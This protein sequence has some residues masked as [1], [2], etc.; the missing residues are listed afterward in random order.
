[1]DHRLEE[2]MNVQKHKKERQSYRRIHKG[3]IRGGCKTTT[4][5]KYAKVNHKK[6]NKNALKNYHLNFISI[7]I[8][9]NED[10]GK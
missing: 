9:C 1:M 8:I 5:L 10:K 6:S 3:V 7:N 4:F 2:Q